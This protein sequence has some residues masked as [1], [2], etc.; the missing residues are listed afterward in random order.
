[1]SSTINGNVG[2]AS[3]SAAQ[4]QC[5]TVSSASEVGGTIRFTNVDGSGNYSFATLPAGSFVISATIAASRYYH[6]PQVIADGT[7]TYSG[8]NLSPT[9]LNANNS[10]TEATNF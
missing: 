2:G 9:A 7:S 6:S 3:F 4:V 8:I 5:L 1:M 10:A